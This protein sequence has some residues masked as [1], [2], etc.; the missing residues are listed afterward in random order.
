MSEIPSD[1]RSRPNRIGSNSAIDLKVLTLNCWGL[2]QPYPIGS[3]DRNFRMRAIADD[4]KTKGKYDVVALE[5]IW[6]ESD[7]KIIQELVVESLPYSFYFHSGFL[8]SGVCV[9]SKGIFPIFLW[10]VVFVFSAK[11]F[12]N[13]WAVAFVI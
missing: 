2:P 13:L 9:F 6:S 5:E 4:L 8:G 7:F 10:G 3:K 11:I 12:S 1:I